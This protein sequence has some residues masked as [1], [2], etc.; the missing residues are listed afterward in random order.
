MASDPGLAPCRRLAAFRVFGKT[1]TTRSGVHGGIGIGAVI[2]WFAG[3]DCVIASVTIVCIL[4]RHSQAVRTFLAVR[5]I[6]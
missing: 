4:P 2:T 5:C 3:V 1:E 6:S